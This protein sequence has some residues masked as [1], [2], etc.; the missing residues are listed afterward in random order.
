MKRIFCL[1]ILAVS[2]FSCTKDKT[3]N[4]VTIQAAASETTALGN[5]LTT[6]SITHQA[7]SRGFFYQ[8]ISQGDTNIRPTICD[9]VVVTYKGTFTTGGVFDES[10]TPIKF[11]LS[12]L[13]VG[14]QEGIPLIGKGGSIK[15]F[16]PP[17]LAYG[18]SGSGSIPGNTNLV[19][20]I[21]LSDVK[22]M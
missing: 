11:K 14:W 19:F 6:N 4:P 20:E 13:I 16:L 5:Y 22:P 15:L 18:A 1:G 2:I 8:I 7:D 12:S 17:S 9:T 21:G 10:T 3:C